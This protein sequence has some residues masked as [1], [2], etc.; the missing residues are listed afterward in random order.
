MA[1]PAGSTDP[2]FEGFLAPV[3]LYPDKG[4][5][6]DSEFSGRR[7]PRRKIR[8]WGVR[9]IETHKD[10]LHQLAPVINLDMVVANKIPT[11]G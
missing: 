10:W 2:E 3:T 6:K 5:D 8:R 4:L 7:R 11:A 1:Q 9:G